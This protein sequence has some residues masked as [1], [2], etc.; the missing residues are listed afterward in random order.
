MGRRESEFTLEP[1]W[2]GL[3]VAHSH[4][5]QPKQTA[6]TMKN[7]RLVDMKTDRRRLSKRSGLAKY[8]ASQASNGPI[9]DLNQYIYAS[10]TDSTSVQT[11]R[12]TENLVVSEG[13]LEK[14]TNSTISAITNGA[15]AFSSTVNQIFSAR[16]YNHVFY[17]DGSVQKFYTGAGSLAAWTATTA[18]TLPTA[19]KLIELW[20]GRIVIAGKAAEPHNWAMSRQFDAFDW[21]FAPD[22]VDEQMAVIGNNSSVGEIGD[23]ITSMIPFSD[24]LLIFGADHSIWQMSGDPAA[25]GRIDNISESIGMAWGRPWCITPEKYILFMGSRGGVWKLTPGGSPPERISQAIDPLLLDLDLE[26]NI[27]RMAFDTRFNQAHLYITPISGTTAGTHYVLDI[28]SGAWMQDVFAS[29]TSDPHSVYL[30]DGD[31]PD[32]RVLLIGSKDGYIRQFDTSASDDDGSAFASDVWLNPIFFRDNNWGILKE[33]HVIMSDSTDSVN[34]DAYGGKTA[35]LAIAA[36]PGF[37]RVLNGGE[38]YSDR[39][40]ATGGRI[41]LR[42]HDECEDGHW[43]LENI[44]VRVDSIDSGRKRWVDA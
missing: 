26:T 10:H 9:Q 33:T 20:R 12:V 44:R 28:E 6:P 4:E 29:Y 24:D 37:T 31:D 35:E 18:G 40:R 34:L 1:P 22:P 25:G 32:D 17:L 11:R 19:H 21:D 38:N 43:S 8:V 27:V 16:L 15:G 13:N 14:F 7:V 5:N 41:F 42:L 39:N 3:H 2:L 30:M 36:E 23:V